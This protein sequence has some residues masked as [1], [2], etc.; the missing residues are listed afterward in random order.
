MTNTIDHF[1]KLHQQEEPLLIGNVWNVQSAQVFERLG[2]KAIATSS[3][4]IAATLGY[5]DGEA[6]SFEEYLFVIKRI[7]KTVN[8]PLSVDLEAGYSNSADTIVENI[9]QLQELGVV[10]I[11]LE[12][13]V[14]SGGTRSIVGAEAFAEKI[15]AITDRL[16]ISKIEMFI[17]LRS[18]VF[19]LGLPGGVEEA[20]ARA[21]MY[22]KTGASGLFFPCVTQLEDIKALAKASNLPL[23]VMCMP[24]LPPFGE[25]KKAGV[26]RI[27]MGNFLNATI[28]KK[29][30]A[31]AQDIIKEGSFHPVFAS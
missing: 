12:D 16:N 6:M 8:L 11:N 25:L 22:A 23:N 7:S 9:K 27:S 13:S 17:N 5:P 4:A 3:S 20:I 30:E 2:L 14:V 24:T 10:G 28:Y 26:K 18:D 15:S 1:R 29:L 21:T 31:I 19:L